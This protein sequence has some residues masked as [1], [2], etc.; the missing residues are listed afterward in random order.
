MSFLMIS[1]VYG[2]DMKYVCFTSSQRRSFIETHAP[3]LLRIATATY[4]RSRL[5]VL[6]LNE[7][8]SYLSTVSFV[9]CPSAT[10]AAFRAVVFK[11][12]SFHTNR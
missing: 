9:L 7:V 1:V 8:L 11:T 5:R 6:M 4:G 3:R 10:L 2:V 12:D